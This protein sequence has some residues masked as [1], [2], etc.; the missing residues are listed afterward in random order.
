[1]SNSN[2]DSKNDRPNNRFTSS[3]VIN[4]DENDSNDNLPAYRQT[5][6]FVASQRKTIPYTINDQNANPFLRN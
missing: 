5:P 4:D 1:M 6:R 3:Y 2:S